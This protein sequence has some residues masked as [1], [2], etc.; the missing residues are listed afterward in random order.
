MVRLGMMLYDFLD[1]EK[2]LPSHKALSKE[3]IF[4]E[5]PS[6]KKEG[7][8]GGCLYYDAEMDDQR[9]VIENIRSAQEMGALSLNQSKVV[10][11]HEKNGKINAVSFERRNTKEIEYVEAH[12]IVNATGAWSN[13]ILAQ[14]K[15]KS[16]CA[17]KPSKGVHLVIPQLH[18]EKALILTTPQDQRIFFALPWKGNTLLGT[19]DTFYEGDPSQLRVEEEDVNYLLT[20]LAHYFPKL[21]LG[22]EC[23]IDSFVGLR[24]L[25]LSKP[26][27]PSSVSRDHLISRSAT[28][29]VTV[30]G[31]KFTT[32]RLIAEEVVDIIG[33]GFLQCS[34]REKSL[35]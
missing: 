24:P 27:D 6:I 16:T 33:A 11:I 29:L 21:P 10:Q 20:A 25:A 3:E 17:V 1:R 26:S 23:V 28:G 14:D 31:G 5:F 4:D 8:K 13:E 15:A 7:L 32:H 19:T 22:K 30:L 18:E 34:T 9:I 35:F 12:Y 2:V